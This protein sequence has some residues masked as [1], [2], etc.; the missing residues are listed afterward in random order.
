MD[1]NV[2]GN[3][4]GS[5]ID[6]NNDNCWGGNGV[7][8]ILLILLFM[9]GGMWGGNR[10]N[11][12]TTQDVATGNMFAQLDNGIRSVQRGIADNGYATLDQFGR[13]NLTIQ[14]TGANL[15]QAIAESTFVAK[16][17][18][19]QTN[20]TLDNVKYDLSKGI[21]NNRY[22]LTR[23]VDA[24]RY[25]TAQQT[26]AITNNAT[27][28]TQKILDKLC[29]MEANAK[30]NEIARLRSDLQAAQLTLAQGVQTQT[31]VGALK[32]S[33][34]PAYVVSSPYCNCGVYGNGTTIA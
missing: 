19:C 4:V 1:E 24:L 13:T 33:P 8:F 31:I 7:W 11:A 23:N 15:A 3:V 22:E 12:A 21:D 17:C 32:P 25:D 14:G 9:G 16:D 28:N 18:C 2:L 10:A 30:D 29:Q 5:L 6:R 34:V 20:R 26:F 27:E